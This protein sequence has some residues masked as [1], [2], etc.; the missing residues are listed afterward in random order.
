[1]KFLTFIFSHLR[2]SLLIFSCVAYFSNA[3]ANVTE[4]QILHEVSLIQENISSSHKEKIERLTLLIEKNSL[5]SWHQAL[6]NSK[7]LKAE[8]LL[9]LDLLND[10]APLINEIKQSFYS[11]LTLSEQSRVLITELNF[12]S[13]RHIQEKVILV[14]KQLDLHVKLLNADKDM[15][16]IGKV[17]KTIGY[18]YVDSDDFTLAIQYFQK[19]YAVLA[20]INEKNSI[21]VAGILSALG[22]VSTKTGDINSAIKYFEKALSIYKSNDEK[23]NQSVVLY[24]IGEAYANSEDAER[25]IL[26]LQQAI[27]LSEQ[28]NDE[29]GVM[30]SKQQLGDI[31][32]KSENWALAL[33]L[34]NETLPVFIN[35]N[36]TFLSYEARI[37]KAHAYLGLG[38]IQSAKFELATATKLKK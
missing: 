16:T 35:A 37:G 9:K 21:A 4:E 5:M 10:A 36:N 7:I 18:S 14:R 30:W 33:S 22:V 38:D 34:F 26:P 27:K 6:F 25:G 15:Q 28:L 11:G 12:Y 2:F 29:M 23:F 20:D 19:A 8:L 24:N 13:K 17:Y 1:M 3:Q 31:A 32:L